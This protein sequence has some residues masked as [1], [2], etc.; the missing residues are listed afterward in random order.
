MDL[1]YK[2]LF[3]EDAFGTHLGANWASNIT[4][5]RQRAALKNQLL[6]EIWRLRIPRGQA[7]NP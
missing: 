3:A 2:Y 7:N 6:E 5:N 4:N 1:V